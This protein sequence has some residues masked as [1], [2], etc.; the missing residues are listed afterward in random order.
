MN[1]RFGIRT[2]LTA[3]VTIV[4]TAAIALGALAV[5]GYVEQRLVANTRDNAE[6]LLAD[7]LDNAAQGAPIV[8]TAE[9]N[10]SGVFFYLDSDGNQITQRQ[11]IETLMSM[12]PPGAGADV[13]SEL[14]LS[15]SGETPP[16]GAGD[17]QSIAIS[18]SAT[19]VGPIQDIDLSHETIALAQRVRF[20][21]GTEMYIGVA[22]SLQPVAESIT[23]IQTILWIFLPILAAGV[24]A[25]TYATVGRVL[26]PVHSITRQTKEITATNLSGRVPVPESRDD[27]AELATTMND[28]LTRLDEAQLRQRQFIAD[29]SHELRSPIAASQSQLEVAL[30]HPEVADWPTTAKHVLHEQ[31][32]LG[33]LVDALLA[34]TSLDE[35][36]IGAVTDIDLSELIS[37]ETGRPHHTAINTI[38]EDQIR[39]TGNRA[40]LAR[41]VRNLIDN[42]DQHAASNVTVTLIREDDVPTIHVDDD[43]PGVPAEQREQIFERFTRLD[44]PRNRNDGGAGLGL[45]IVRQVMQ[46]HGGTVQCTESPLGGARI[47]IRLPGPL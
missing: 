47:S 46:S 15:Q 12:G 18:I 11:Y 5:V 14:H 30:A 16:A 3:L 9:P 43:G 29:A 37:H 24:G 22:N 23:A 31:T 27:I 2:R 13:V 32:Q 44:E 19:R 33:D 8:A 35:Q 21:D 40:H 1:R 25:L 7:Y 36:G 28:M 20:I 42:A 6:A 17:E 39:V 45:A 34:L 10:E 38:V 41:A 4:F 26:R